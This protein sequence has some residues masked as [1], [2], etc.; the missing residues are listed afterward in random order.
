M[1]HSEDRIERAGQREEKPTYFVHPL[2]SHTS[3]HGQSKAEIAPTNIGFANQIGEPQHDQDESRSVDLRLITKR[4]L[5]DM[6]SD[7]RELSKRFGRI[8]L[9]LAIQNVFLLTKAYDEKLIT[10]T[11]II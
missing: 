11:R 2:L 6:A 8:R 3:H 9:L 5:S 1:Q 10:F 7:I 4:Q